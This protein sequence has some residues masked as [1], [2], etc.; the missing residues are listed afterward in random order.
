M[1][2][3]NSNESLVVVIQQMGHVP[4]F[5]NKKLIARGRLITQPKVRRW[6]EK[7]TQGLHS[8]LKSLFQ[9]SEEE[10]SM[11]PWQLSAIASWPA[12]DNW[13]EIPSIS[14]RVRIVEKGNEG[15]IIT[16]TR[17]SP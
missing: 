14:T 8:Q 2:S 11:V 4:A 12:D 3:T 10:T 16:L 15:A 7:A 1:S 5:K 6:M 17:I 13:K 9:T